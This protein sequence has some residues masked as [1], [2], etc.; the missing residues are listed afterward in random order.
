MANVESKFVS[1][2]E[3]MRIVGLTQEEVDEVLLELESESEND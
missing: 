3:D 1:E 2:V